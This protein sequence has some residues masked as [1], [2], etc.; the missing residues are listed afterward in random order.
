METRELKELIQTLSQTD[1]QYIEVEH[2]GSRLVLSKEKRAMETSKLIHS[3]QDDQV[4]VEETRP[5]KRVKEEETDIYIVKSPM[6]GTF[7][8]AP[9]PDQP[10][11]VEVGQTIKKGDTLCIIE[12]MK[13]MNAIDSEVRGEILEIL[14]E[15]EAIVEFGQPIF[16]VKLCG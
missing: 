9:A 16:K 15:N 11:F 10:P 4:I 1:Y 5:E 8:E 7:Y 13:L 2:E 6:I 14:I 3:T 12:A